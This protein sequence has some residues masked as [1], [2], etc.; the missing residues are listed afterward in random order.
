MYLNVM[1]SLPSR[2]CFLMYPGI[3]CGITRSTECTIILCDVQKGER[4]P[5][6]YHQENADRVL[7]KPRYLERPPNMKTSPEFSL[8][9][10]CSSLS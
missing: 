4:A 9:V 7:V 10:S 3:V 6:R 2:M 1:F 5:A 8:T